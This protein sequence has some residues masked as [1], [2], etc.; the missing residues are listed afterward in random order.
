MSYLSEDIITKD[1]TVKCN[2]FIYSTAIN[3]IF[4]YYFVLVVLRLKYTVVTLALFSCVLKA[5]YFVYNDVE[6]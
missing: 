5:D 2:N 4:L 3:G 6:K 1:M